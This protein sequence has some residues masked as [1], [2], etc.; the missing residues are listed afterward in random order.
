MNLEEAKATWERELVAAREIASKAEAENRNLTGEEMAKVK[1]HIDAGNQAK[2]IVKEAGEQDGVKNAMAELGM[3]YADEEKRTKTGLVV[4][5]EGDTMGSAFTKS[6]AFNDLVK[7]LPDSPGARSRMA[8]QSGTYKYGEKASPDLVTGLAGNS[9]GAFITNDRLNILER[10]GR[11]PLTMRDIV[12]KG[13]TDSDT[14]EYVREIENVNNAAFVPEATT[15]ALPT[16]PGTAGALVNNP[17]GGYKPKGK[18]EFEVVTETVKTLAEWMPVTN[19]ALSDA[20]QIRT[21][22]DNKLRDDLAEVEDA[23]LLTG[24]GTGENLRG[25]MNVSGVL[26]QNSASTVL[27][28]NDGMKMIEQL[29]KAKTLIRTTGRASATAVVMSPAD[30]EE[31]WLARVDKNPAVDGSSAAGDQIAGLTVVENELMADGTALVGD[32]SRAV[33]FDREGVSLSV[34]NSHADFFIRNLVAVL[35]EKRLGFGVIRPSAFCKV[36]FNLA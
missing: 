19:R 4:P 10:L 15:D 20:S 1:A 13:T 32:F 17:G 29:K 7:T 30:Y 31:V 3:G 26:T 33:I 11:R 27:T 25:L 16:A 24:N 18:F 28:G 12:S 21:L 36:T 2:N 22:I 35:A 34:T 9:A 5:S 8:I 14:I 6:D 23:Q